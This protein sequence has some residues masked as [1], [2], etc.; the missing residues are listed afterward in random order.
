MGQA[1]DEQAMRRAVEERVARDYRALTPAAQERY[2]AALRASVRAAK[3]GRPATGDAEAISAGDLGIGALAT[4]GVGLISI[5][6]GP[7][8]GVVLGGAAL[9]AMAAAR[10]ADEDGDALAAAASGDLTLEKALELHLAA[11]AQ[12]R[13]AYYLAEN[14]AGSQSARR[15]V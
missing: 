7:M 13:R 9:T 14:P 12:S 10:R 4:I 11:M 5:T 1:F 2:R 3:M 8:A 6:V 15:T